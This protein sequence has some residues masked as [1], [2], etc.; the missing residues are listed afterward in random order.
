MELIDFYI[1]SI[2]P[3]DEVQKM[4][5]EKSSMGAVGDLNNFLKYSLAK[6]M[7][8]N[9]GAAQAG[10][11]IGMGAGIG[12]VVPAML[13]K[14]FCPDD[15]DLK[16]ESLTT[17]TCPKCGNDTPQNSRFCYKCGHQMVANNRCP[18][19]GTDLPLDAQFC[20]ACGKKL[21]EKIICPKC[22]TKLPTGSKFCTNCGEKIE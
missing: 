18:D 14:A 1:T 6:A 13:S 9:V 4:I 11:G 2:T 16:T 3:P 19:C 7:S 15:K 22:N 8:S 17:T 12:L 21:G 10:T 20:F 5:D